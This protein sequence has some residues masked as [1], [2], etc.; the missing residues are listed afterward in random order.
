MQ[1]SGHHVTDMLCNH[2]FGASVKGLLFA[3]LAEKAVPIVKH[4]LGDLYHDAA[5]LDAHVTGPC[6]FYYSVRLTGTSI[7]E[8]A[9]LV[10][11]GAY[12]MWR[13]TLDHTA[14]GFWASDMTEIE[15]SP[16]QN[17]SQP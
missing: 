1:T 15:L 4:Y 12:K 17:R 7:G 6:T 13:V 10:E 11:I 14:S 3:K 8:N 9:S 16:I 2:D 5:W